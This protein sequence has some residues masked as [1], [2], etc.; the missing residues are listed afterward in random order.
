MQFIPIRERI[1]PVSFKRI[2]PLCKL[3]LVTQELRG[4]SISLLLPVMQKIHLVHNLLG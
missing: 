1:V 4:K 3:T 2:A